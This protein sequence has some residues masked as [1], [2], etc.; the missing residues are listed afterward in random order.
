[1]RKYSFLVYHK[2]YLDFL[3]K[4]RD[5]GVLHIIEKSEGVSENETLNQ[6]MQLRAKLKSMLRQLQQELTKDVIPKSA[7]VGVDGYALMESVERQYNLL[8]SLHQKL[9]S[10]ERE[11]ERMEVWGS[12]SHDRLQ[13]LEEAGFELR[14]FCC[15]V[16]KFDQEWEVLYNA[17]EIDTIGTLRYFVTVNKPGVEVNIDADPVRISDNNAAEIRQE[18]ESVKDE[19]ASVKENI[20]KLAI[21]H[22]NAILAYSQEV[23]GEI[24]FS[25]VMLN[26]RSEVENK[27]M[28]LEGWCPEENVAALDEYLESSGVYFESAE[29]AKEEQVPIKLKNNKFARLYEMIGELYDLPNYSEIDLTPF[30]APFF[31]LFFGLCVGDTAY[32]LII[33]LAAIFMRR[34]AKPSM[35]PVFS[36]A[37]WL[38][39]STVI[40]GFVSGTFLGFNLIEAEI[41][42]LEKFKVIM[43][44]SN[45][46][47]YTALIVGIVQILFGMIIKAVGQ[48]IRFGFAASLASWG[49]LII[50]LGMGG[51]YAASNFMGID[52]QVTK[53]LYYGFG[54][55][56]ALLVFILNDIKRNPL[57]NVG[58]GLWDTYNVATG[59][60]G[61]LLSYIRLFALGISSSVMGFVFNDLAMKMSGDIPVLNIIIMLVILLIGHGINIF[62]AC[63]GGFVHPMRLTFVEFYKN[64]GFEGGGKKYKPFKQ[65]EKQL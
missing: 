65:V 6:Q 26:T 36:L 30:F 40:L 9:Q 62:M 37:I 47:F 5:I 16:R 48:V 17:F 43:L 7:T 39:A 22:Y 45:Q 24:D 33:L 11:W 50:I 55:L 42:W 20:R 23:S 29:P 56:G 28:L 63:L 12:F 8:D 3:D 53:Y 46:L 35:K 25:K 31:L 44:D 21:E 61:D 41:P 1:M 2:I 34:K 27:V 4:I 15:N 32:G 64:A 54:G 49:W 52:P 59:F 14:F 51:T 60:L 10:A 13:E 19:I 38:G 57:I 58:A 18:I